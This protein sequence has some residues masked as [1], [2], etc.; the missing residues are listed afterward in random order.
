MS[1]SSETHSFKFGSSS[2]NVL[3]LS[4]LMN[5]L[6]SKTLI[7]EGFCALTDVA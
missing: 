2:L 7:R 5:S 1:S 6:E 3:S 4:V